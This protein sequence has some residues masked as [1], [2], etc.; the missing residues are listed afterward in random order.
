M[1]RSRRYAVT[2]E[3]LPDL[4]L[5]RMRDLLGPEEFDAFYEALRRPPTGAIRVNTLKVEVARFKEIS[6][7]PLEP[8][9]WCPE[10][11]YI[12][13]EVEPGKHPYHAAGLY[14]VQEPTA[15]AVGVVAAP[16]PWEWVADL[17]AAPGGKSTHL[18]ASM[19]D[20]GF[21]LANDIDRRRTTVLA[22]NLE[23]WGARVWVAANE[24][25]EHLHPRFPEAFDTVVLDA[26]CTGEGMFRRNRDVVAHWSPRAVEGNAK[27]QFHLLN[28]AAPLVKPGGYLVY[29]TCTFNPEENEGVVAR[30]LHAHPEF[31]LEP[32]EDLPGASPGRPDWI[33]PELAR[34]L[35]LE[36]CLRFW[37]HK[38][39]GEG[40]FIALMVKE[41][42]YRPRHPLNVPEA[43]RPK[44][45]PRR[46]W[47]LYKAWCE[48]TLVEMP[49]LAGLMLVNDQLY[50]CPI[51]PGRLQDL[52]IL[53]PGLWL[54]TVKQTTFLPDHALA[55]W[56][57]PDMVKRRLD[58]SVDDPRVIAYLRGESLDAPGDDGWVLVTV[59]GFSLGW[60]KRVRG[61]LKNRYPKHLR[62]TW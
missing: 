56:L 44:G 18:L 50:A 23:R 21:L 39:R 59:D 55:M 30:F 58:L 8:V 36:R 17:A 7:F 3:Q 32:V 31:S 10:G 16:Q 28:A 1:T 25:I 27:R 29:A 34:G 20:K 53:R 26:P 52:R 9:P 43:K 62:W 60:G 46:A 14:Y 49:R 51:N 45:M 54:G 6:P 38:V 41:G 12:P 13:P 2:P 42:L 61:V 15:M 35:P 57:R 33:D 22:Q 40:H 5:L 48:D 47:N 37:P 24:R 19:E 4:F 11:F